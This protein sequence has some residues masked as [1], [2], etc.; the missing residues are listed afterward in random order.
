MQ[1]QPILDLRNGRIRGFEALARMKC[2][3]LGLVPPMEFIPI[4]EATRQIL[5][6]GDRIMEKTCRF[7]DR[8]KRAGYDDLSIAINISAMQLLHPGFVPKLIDILREMR[9][10]PNQ[11]VLELTETSFS[12][13]YERIDDLMNE[14]NRYGITF[15][16]DDFGTG[17]SSLSRE[18]ELSVSCLKI[19]KLF[20]DKL[21]YLNPEQTITGDII[22]MAHRLG[23]CVVAEGVEHEKQLRYL[24][25][26]GC[27]EVQGYLIS[28]PLDEEDAIAFLGNE[29]NPAG[30]G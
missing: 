2:E 5:Q 4:A 3:T 18:R 12:S 7:I 25:E 11:V 24:K 29:K 23:H 1:Y 14:L 15:S 20:I 19:D 26:H 17:Y 21:E 9:V 6:L 13:E 10:N 27:D 28:K 8:L 22:S 30:A 16:I